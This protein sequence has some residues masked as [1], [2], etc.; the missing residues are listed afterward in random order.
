M[1]RVLIVQPDHDAASGLAEVLERAG[2][3]SD[4]VDTAPLAMRRLEAGLYDLVMADLKLN[5]ESG[6]SLLVAILSRWPEL[7]VIMVALE[8][9]VPE[10]IQAMRAGASDFLL[11]P[12]AAEEVLYV[13]A[14][15]LAGM[16]LRATEPP[17]AAHAPDASLI[18][19]SVA[20]RRVDEMIQRTAAGTATV[21]VR[22]ESGTGK[23][24]V[25]RAIHRKSPRSARPFVKIDC[26]SL[27]ETLLEAEL[28]GHEKGAF[29]GAVMRKPGRVELAD[30]G[31]LFLDEIGE[32]SAPVQ[33]KL[34]RLLQDRQF[35]RLGGKQTLRIDVRFVVATHRDLET[36]VKNGSFRHD[37]FYRLN[38]VPLWL[39]PL[40]ARR[41]DIVLLATHF[42]AKFAVANGR[43]GLFISPEGL[44]FL[45]SQRWPGNVRQLENFIERLVVL[46]D[47]SSIE[48]AA[49]Q[50]ELVQRPE[51]TT[52]STG[53]T[54]ADSFAEKPGPALQDAVRQA[55]R[56][57]LIGALKM[58]GGN[59]SVA[60]RVL[61][62]SRATLYNKLKE[63]GLSDA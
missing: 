55:E 52:Q 61:G 34:L 15:A 17:L 45:R 47:G 43:P 22:G 37:L 33:A 14:K 49:I 24:L 27:P 57:A 26:S 2:H 23:E 51:F 20:M 58:S 54:G 56:D 31:T 19:Q 59:R 21:L 8:S 28:F 63:L 53:N 62:V 40:R 48:V 44:R 9:T 1:A 50:R 60:A 41:D 29:T 12:F 39:P 16:A 7:P 4:V 13:S 5:A 36:M 25:A 3:L 42:C 38:V 35:E 30:G 46:A 6:L 11:K 32:V 10:A 18:G